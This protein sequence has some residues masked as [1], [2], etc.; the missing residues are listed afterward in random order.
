QLRRSSWTTLNGDWE[1]AIDRDARWRMPSEVAYERRIL[2]PFA[3][4]TVRSGVGERGFFR[5][6]WYRRTFSAPQRAAGDRV[7][8]H[9]GAVDHSAIVWVN[10]ARVVRHEGGY[11]PFSADVTDQL[12][13]GNEEIV[14]QC[15]DDP[16][17][18]AK[19][20]G[21]QDWQLEPHSIWYPR[22]SGIWQTV[23]VE[24]VPETRIG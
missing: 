18:L 14:V 23:W 1:F 3:P 7:L 8:L 21:K 22:C 13:G 5:A 20:R 24:V 2:V 12:R 19:P 16:A 11:T 9:F 10:G 4:E 6:C 15:E 17:D